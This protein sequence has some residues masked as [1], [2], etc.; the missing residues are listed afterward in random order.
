MKIPLDKDYEIS[1]IDGM[2][3]TLKQSEVFPVESQKCG[4]KQVY[5]KTTNRTNISVFIMVRRFFICRTVRLNTDMFAGSTSETP[6]NRDIKRTEV[7]ATS[8]AS[9][10]LRNGIASIEV[11]PGNGQVVDPAYTHT[12]GSK[13]DDSK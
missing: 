2:I 3:N 12:S 1:K 9:H 6:L 5:Q 10:S 11:F 4:V 13:R 7:K 8:A